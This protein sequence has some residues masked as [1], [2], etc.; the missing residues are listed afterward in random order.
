MN[1]TVRAA[2]TVPRA[3][4]VAVSLRFSTRAVSTVGGGGRVAAASSA[5]DLIHL[6]ATRPAVDTSA[7]MSTIAINVRWR[8]A[9][10]EL[11]RGASSSPV[12]QLCV[13]RTSKWLPRRQDLRSVAQ[14][15]LMPLLHR[16]QSLSTR[17]DGTL[18][19]CG[20]DR[21]ANAR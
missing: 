4:R 11:G 5:G 10:R 17:F 1:S 9:A 16:V 12:P 18:L 8:R 21:H 20:V 15:P 14:L 3:T 7:Q 19:I 6:V 13:A 2:E